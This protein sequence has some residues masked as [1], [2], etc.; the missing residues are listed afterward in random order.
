VVINPLE[1]DT[2]NPPKLEH[3]RKRMSGYVGT[4]FFQTLFGLISVYMG[5]SVLEPED[6]GTYAIVSIISAVV[7]SLA[8]GPVGILSAGTYLAMTATEQE[9]AN[10]TFLVLSVLFSSIF[11]VLLYIVWTFVAPSMVQAIS[12]KASLFAILSVFPQSLVMMYTCLYYNRGYSGH[13]FLCTIVQGFFT[14]TMLYVGFFLLEWHEV[15]LYFGQLAGYSASVVVSILLCRKIINPLDIGLASRWLQNYR[16]FFFNA[17]VSNSPQMLESIVI[18]KFIGIG[19]VAVWQHAKLYSSLLLRTIKIISLTVWPVSLIEAKNNNFKNTQKSW[20]LIYAGLALMGVATV[21]LVEPLI[22]F[23]THGKLVGASVLVPWWVVYC[24][25]QNTGKEAEA[26]LYTFNLGHLAVNAQTYSKMIGFVAF[27]VLTWSFG[28]SGALGAAILE[29]ICYR[30]FIRRAVILIKQ[31]PVIDIWAFVCAGLMFLAICVESIIEPI[32]WKGRLL[33]LT[34][35][36]FV[37]V[38]LSR[39]TIMETSDLI[40]TLNITGS[41]K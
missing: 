28:L 27:I 38:F 15:S 8:A 10:T 25:I 21:F 41:P 16:S 2:S 22:S 39:K 11:V 19:S 12:P 18:T 32:T 24:L 9:R 26:V 3:W 31:L 20:N 17:I 14:I 4:V 40:K 37:I 23:L 33:G 1:R 6:Y 35:G 7:A 13:V 36:V 30:F 5:L 34:V 29:V